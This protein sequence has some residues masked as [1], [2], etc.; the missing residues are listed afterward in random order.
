METIRAMS[1]PV[2]LC[3][4]KVQA[5]LKEEIELCRDTTEEVCEEDYRDTLDSVAT[6]IKEMA[7][8]LFPENPY[9]VAT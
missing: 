3:H 6:L 1:Q 5:E 4:N 2:D 8:E 9:S 7:V